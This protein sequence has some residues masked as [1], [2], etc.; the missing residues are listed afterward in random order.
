[1]KAKNMKNYS[2]IL[3][4]VNHR[5]RLDGSPPLIH[6]ANCLNRSKIITGLQYFLVGRQNDLS[7]IYHE[8]FDELRSDIYWIKMN[9]LVCT[10]Y[11]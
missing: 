10:L 3:A 1:M 5:N 4:I 8:S 6:L 2:S 9:L 7:I 11:I